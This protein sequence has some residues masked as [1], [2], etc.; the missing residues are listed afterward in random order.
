MRAAMA[1]LRR[2]QAER[3]VAA[4]PVAQASAHR[5]LEALAD[6]MVCLAVP[7]IFFTVGKWYVNFEQVSD[8]QMT[9]LLE[10]VTTT[11]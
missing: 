6:Q 10:Q 9:A 2:L 1:A 8:E 3:V 4:V 7:D 5:E 11:V